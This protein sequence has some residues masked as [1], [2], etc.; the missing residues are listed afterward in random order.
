MS[1]PWK[2]KRARSGDIVVTFEWPKQLFDLRS[3]RWPVI[4]GLGLGVGLSLV[5]GT[6]PSLV[7]A[8]PPAQEVQISQVFPKELKLLRNQHVLQD[9]WMTEFG[10]WKTDAGQAFGQPGALVLTA[11]TSSADQ[12]I[13]Q[14][15]LGD[16]IEITGSNSATYRFTVVTISRASSPEQAVQQSETYQG[17]RVILLQSTKP[18]R[19]ERFAIIAT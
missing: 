19:T 11:T 10:S 18:W 16:T 3:I 12:L 8:E 17:D 1:R 15:R 13:D 5:W 9:L 7:T 6:V 14:A 4:L 2:V